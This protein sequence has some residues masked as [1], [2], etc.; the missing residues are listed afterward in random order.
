MTA[1]QIDTEGSPAGH[2]RPYDRVARVLRSL[3]EM[4]MAGGLLSFVFLFFVG[5]VVMLLLFATVHNQKPETISAKVHPRYEQLITFWYERGYLRHGGLWMRGSRD[6]FSAPKPDQE[7]R[8]A[9][10]TGPMAYLQ[11]AH[12]LE[13]MHFLI[14]GRYSQTLMSF[15]NQAL[16][17]VSAALLGWLA[18]RLALKLGSRSLHALLPG[19]AVLLVFQTFPPNLAYYWETTSSSAMSIFAIAF[20]LSAEPFVTD[21]GVDRRIGWLRGC[22]VFGMFW[23][24]PYIAAF[25]V[26]MY[27]LASALFGYGVAGNQRLATTVAL[28]AVLAIGLFAAQILWVKLTIPDLQWVGHASKEGILFRTGLD[29]SALYVKG[30]IDLLRFNRFNSSLKWASLFVG[31]VLS[32]GAILALQHKVSELKYPTF[33]LAVA[34]GLYLPFAFVFGQ[35]AAIHPY[36]YDLYMVIP[37]V[38]SLF[39]VLPAAL[40]RLAGNRGVYTFAFFL[41]ALCYAMVS[42]RTYAMDYPV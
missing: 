20:L 1:D 28:P 22:C 42:L 7:V 31:G 34:T 27:I 19:I 37:L 16:V 40:E 5:G 4:I 30:H 33:V 17:W 8:L 18:M 2:P 38:L 23:V 39:A 13:R 25:F 21:T 41:I 24:D 26:A 29:G 10:K 14:R 3:L 15:H 35:G 9:Y 11:G 36:I 12:L 32:L 6:D